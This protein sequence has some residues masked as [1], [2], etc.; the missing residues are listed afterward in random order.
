MCSDF[1]ADINNNHAKECRMD[2][3]PRFVSGIKAIAA[4]GQL[5][6][7][8]HSELE[9]SILEIPGSYNSHG[10][11][12]TIGEKVQS[13]SR[14][15]QEAFAKSEQSLAKL[16]GTFWE[17]ASSRGSL[18]RV[19]EL[20]RKDTPAIAYSSFRDEWDRIHRYLC[21][22]QSHASACFE[23][24]TYLLTFIQEFET[25]IS[26]MATDDKKLTVL[27]SG[28]LEKAKAE[29]KTRR[30]DIDQETRDTKDSQGF[31]FT[32]AVPLLVAILT[33]LL[34]SGILFRAIIL[35][36]MF[37]CALLILREGMEQSGYKATSDDNDGDQTRDL[38]IEIERLTHKH[39]LSA[40][41]GQTLQELCSSLASAIGGVREIHDS[42]RAMS[43]RLLSM[44]EEKID[45]F[46][47]ALNRTSYIISWDES[48]NANHTTDHRPR[49]SK[50]V[51]RI[52]ELHELAIELRL[53]FYIIFEWSS[54]YTRISQ[55]IFTPALRE[56]QSFSSLAMLISGIDLSSDRFKLRPA[57]QGEWTPRQT[58]PPLTRSFMPLA[59]IP[60]TYSADSDIYCS[61][62]YVPTA[63]D[64]LTLNQIAGRAEMELNK[65]H[66]PRKRDKICTRESDGGLYHNYANSNQRT[67]RKAKAHLKYS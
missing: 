60:S 24:W 36:C 55:D 5:L 12:L 7:V 22:V 16:S 31:D 18:H 66:R 58:A 54:L 14:L 34:L 10:K 8:T 27:L 65:L 4:L 23:S 38:E 13:C 42:Y 44:N 2:W 53:T 25:L 3:G 26:Y 21:D 40:T 39:K 52:K 28:K 63:K 67:Q 61:Q 46:K 33:V 50:D 43:E 47:K 1:L 30:Y 59:T 15:Y 57:Q 17:L 9:V 11:P 19:T 64:T 29:I 56:V 62:S 20:F 48:Y 41:I 45:R 6:L 51:T 32:Y 35:S 37:L 49:E